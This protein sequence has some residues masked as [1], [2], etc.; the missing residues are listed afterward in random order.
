M[1]QTDMYY[2]MRRVFLQAFDIIR[3]KDRWTTKDYAT[4]DQGVPTDPRLADAC[5]FCSAGAIMKFRN[6]ALT[7]SAFDLRDA[8]DIYTRHLFKMSLHAFNDTKPYDQV[9]ELWIHLGKSKGYLPDSFTLADP[10]PEV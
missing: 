9:V 8:F 10:T 6:G 5:K 7:Q 4:T 1:K 3:N 2:K